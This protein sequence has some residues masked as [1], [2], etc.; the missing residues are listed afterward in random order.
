MWRETKEIFFHIFLHDKIH[1]K[2]LKKVCILD[3][4]RLACV[5]HVLWVCDCIIFIIQNS[6]N[7]K[8]EICPSFIWTIKLDTNK[9]WQIFEMEKKLFHY[10]YHYP[11]WNTMGNTTNTHNIIICET[12]KRIFFSNKNGSNNDN[13]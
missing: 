10:Y 12:I 8:N 11:L 1:Y 13:I 5:K 3:I 2:N 9:R 4:Q 6:L 7:D